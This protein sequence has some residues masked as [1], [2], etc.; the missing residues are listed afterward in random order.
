MNNTESN[1]P[2][3]QPINS[4]D[5]R[6][7]GV[8]IEKAKTTPDNYPLSLTA[9]CTG[10]NQKSNRSPLMNLETDLAEASLERL[11]ELGVVILIQGSGRVD[12]YRH[13]A[14]TWLGA[15]KVEL[16]VIAELLLRGPQTEGELRGRAARMEPIS[17]LSELKPI[18]TSLQQK[19][20][21]IRLTPA[22][23]G[24]VV[25]HALYKEREIE[26]LQAQHGSIATAQG[27]PECQTAAPVSTFEP[28]CEPTNV[29]TVQDQ[30]TESLQEEIKTLRDQVTSLQESIG[31]LTAQVK[32]TRADL[33]QL[34]L[35]LGEN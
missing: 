7:L 26:K 8:L 27:A 10:A 4:T 9:I 31:Q 28:S 35:A 24:A 13:N 12:K 20:L 34:K 21:L 2:L 1:Q 14:Y 22:G 29:K 18:L 30:S 11:R 19:G 6:V 3:W 15:D 25:T 16:A 23:R 32:S 17:G 33:E 5:R